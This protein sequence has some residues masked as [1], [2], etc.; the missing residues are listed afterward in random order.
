[1]MPF[2]ATRRPP[3]PGCQ[4]L[5]VSFNCVCD[6][7]ALLRDA[8]CTNAAAKGVVV[9]VSFLTFVVVVCMGCAC[10]VTLFFVGVV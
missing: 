3:R 4:E 1:M 5:G 6:D 9:G 8:R 7:M 10:G 2:L